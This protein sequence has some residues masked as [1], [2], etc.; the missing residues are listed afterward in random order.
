MA[1]FPSVLRVKDYISEVIRSYGNDAWIPLPF[2]L[3]HHFIQSAFTY[4]AWS[5]EYVL[6]N[7]DFFTLPGQSVRHRYTHYIYKNQTEKSYFPTFF[8]NDSISHGLQQLAVAFPKDVKYTV[9]DD[10]DSMIDL[11]TFTIKDVLVAIEQKLTTIHWPDEWIIQHFEV[12]VPREQYDKFLSHEIVMYCSDNF[13]CNPD[14]TYWIITLPMDSPHILSKQSIRFN[15]LTKTKIINGRLQTAIFFENNRLGAVHGYPFLMYLIDKQF[16]TKEEY[17]WGEVRLP[18]EF[19]LEDLQKQLKEIS[20][21]Q[22]VDLHSF[23]G[24]STCITHEEWVAVLGR[25]DGLETETG[26]KAGTKYLEDNLTDLAERISTLED[27]VCGQ[28]KIDLD[29]RVSTLESSIT[30][31]SNLDSK[32]QEILDAH[33]ELAEAVDCVKTIQV[34]ISTEDMKIAIESGGSSFWGN[35]LGGVA[36]GALGGLGSALGSVISTK[37]QIASAIGSNAL[38]SING[39]LAK[40]GAGTLSDMGK[41]VTGMGQAFDGFTAFQRTSEAAQQLINRKLN[42]LVQN[43]HGKFD[44]LENITTTIDTISK[45]TDP[46][47]GETVQMSDKIKS[48]IRTGWYV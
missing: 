38:G 43:V 28:N 30:R 2:Q 26:E 40:A 12:D 46:E 41:R 13:F 10:I 9:P 37:G 39:V 48:M 33:E 29:K 4:S 18:I 1:L 22:P 27:S 7:S 47:T 16:V 31:L 15:V 5:R 34:K 8:I 11:N 6:A 44:T 20:K 24:C 19:I 17:L 45:W 42:N 35:L 3:I 36:G 21:P 32:A 23:L 14:N 25:L